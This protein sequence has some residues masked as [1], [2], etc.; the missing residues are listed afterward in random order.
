VLVGGLAAVL[1]DSMSPSDSIDRR[2]QTLRSTARWL[3]FAILAIAALALLGWKTRKPTLFYFIPGS[4]AMKVNTAIAFLF[5]GT[6][7][8]CLTR[9]QGEGTGK[10]WMRKLGM[11]CG[12]AMGLIGA[13]TLLEYGLG[14]NLHIDEIFFTE[15]QTAVRSYFAGRMSDLSAF[16]FVCLGAAFWR[17]S[18]RSSDRL[19]QGL[20]FV[21]ALATLVAVVGHLYGFNPVHEDS[22][23]TPVALQTAFSFLLLCAGIL[24]ARP[25]SDFM[26]LC[27]S[28]GVSGTIVRRLCPAA[29]LAPLLGGWL[30]L[31]GHRLG[32]FDAQM[33][34]L[35][36]SAGAIVLFVGVVCWNGWHLFRAEESNQRVEGELN[37]SV[38]RF[39][40]LADSMPQI[41]W[42][43][44]P[45]G[46]FDYFNKAW[47]DYTGLTFEQT[48]DWSWSRVVNPDDLAQ[49]VES[50][51][52]SLQTGRPYEVEYRFKRASDG[53]YRWHLGRALPMR[54]AEGTITQWVGACTDIHEQ[55][56]AKEELTRHVEA[57]TAELSVANTLLHS[58]I[59]ERERAERRNQQ[60]F[61]Y[62]LDVI[63]TIDQQGRFTQVSAAAHKVWGYEPEELVGRRFL[64]LV[65][66]EDQA[67]TSEMVSKI[68]QGEPVADFENRYI[69]KDGSLVTISWAANWSEA[70]KTMFCVAHDITDRHHSTEQL[71][72]SEERFRSVAQSLGDA[73][74]STDSEGLIIFWNQAAESIFG[75]TAVEVLGQPLTVIMPNSFA[76]RHRED[77]QQHQTTG[78]THVL[79][80]NIELQGL[81]KSGRV[82][83]IE[84]SLSTWETNEG[85]FYTGIVR[86]ITLRNKIEEEL[87][88]AKEAAEA[89]S[90][91]KSEFLANISHEIRTPLNGIL[92]MT[93]LALDLDLSEKA[94]RNLNV[95]KTS[96]LSLLALL[97]DLLDLS[98]IE[99]G[100]LTLEKI[101]FDL[102][103][104]L[105]ATLE[106]L[107]GS[108]QNKSLSL[109]F[110]VN[111]AVPRTIVGDPTRLGQIITNLVDNAIKFTHTGVVTVEVGLLEKFNDQTHLEFAISDTGIGIP[112]EKQEIIFE[113][114]AQADGSTTRNYGG[115]GLGLCICA[116]L[117]KQM[118]GKIEVESALGRG[119][120]FKFSGCFGLAD[121]ESE[122]PA[123]PPRSATPGKDDQPVRLHHR[124]GL[125]ILVA[126]DNPI[127]REVAT[128]LLE[129]AGYA[130]A[131]ANDG[132]EAVSLYRRER[133]DLVLMDVQMPSLDGLAATREIRDL[134]QKLGRSAP[135]IAMTAHAMAGDR[136]RCL[137]AGMN[138][139]VSKPLTKKALL[140]AIDSVF[141]LSAPVR[142][143]IQVA[144][145]LPDQRELLNELDG[146]SALLERLGGLFAE[147]TPKLMTAMN[148]A[149]ERR[150]A[151]A[152]EE[153][154]HNLLSSLGVFR[155]QVATR[156][157]LKLEEAGREADFS[158]VPELLSQLHNEID[159]IFAAL[160]EHRAVASQG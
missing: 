125:R 133:F 91:A 155:A 92:G 106:P 53:T 75:H 80:R 131:L 107:R 61:A 134:E 13:A 77:L 60:I 145:H 19:A 94:R 58:Q 54:D 79:G 23:Y 37:E 116:G 121:S 22:H 34:A 84:L 46:G 160:A 139:Y 109:L 72:A 150:D 51:K 17:F 74:I 126:E 31:T 141:R 128:G 28:R 97:N 9:E 110:R 78:K 18:G 59:L 39:A 47:Y 76:A 130:L 159:S 57:R 27:T 2:A 93:D 158:K 138:A 111:S 108:A 66:P 152:L 42:T 113:A 1:R 48:E 69:C 127:N 81:H 24:C 103:D 96:G 7:L 148:D 3:A 14:I 11:S 36:F 129:N 114:F 21:G 143:K 35:I 90:R 86:D 105:D 120:K 65:V 151:K 104:S 112:A 87:R 70:E 40:F 50:W 115:T 4:S 95:A 67:K 73:I 102:R 10:R 98:K 62:S 136:E 16:I 123:P 144:T 89:A 122:L 137:A 41:I 52:R 100:K 63:C 88:E 55:K 38:R 44:R 29:I 5:S 147:N 82:F 124:S 117:V 118:K 156:L 85:H 20:V 49:C 25:E 140:A 132:H 153:L 142:E 146:D 101:P 30:F 6:G 45:D 43:A 33:E 99:A 119:S 71:R 15:S 157:T 149:A 8:I 56:M 83:P 64:D 135:I 26:R 154:A 32:L 68:I 12:V